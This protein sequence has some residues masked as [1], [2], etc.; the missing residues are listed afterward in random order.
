MSAKTSLKDLQEQ[1]KSLGLKTYGT[2]QT[3]QQR[4]NGKIAEIPTYLLFHPESNEV[5]LWFN[6]QEHIYHTELKSIGINEITKR[7]IEKLLKNKV[8]FPVRILSALRGMA[9]KEIPNPNN[10]FEHLCTNETEIDFCF[11]FSAIK[12]R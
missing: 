6:K 7:E 8:V 5:S 10:T 4:I 3:L 2:K 9:E 12:S 11:M 1:C